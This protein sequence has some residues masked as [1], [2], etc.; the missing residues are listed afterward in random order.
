M[1]LNFTIF[2]L[3]LV[4]GALAGP[5]EKLPAELELPVTVIEGASQGLAAL[6]LSQASKGLLRYRKRL[7]E[8]G[9]HMLV[10]AD[11]VMA[12]AFWH[13]IV[14]RSLFNATALE[15]WFITAGVGWPNDFLNTSPDHYLALNGPGVRQPGKTADIIENWGPG[16][17]THFYGVSEPKPSFI[18]AVDEFPAELQYTVG[19]TLLDGT[20]FAHT[21]TAFRDLP[22]ENGIEVIGD[23]WI[24]S[25]SPDDVIEGLQAHNTVEISNWLKFAWKAA[26][27]AL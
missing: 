8:D 2:L 14:A 1:V 27:A 22:G 15:Q 16:P 19:F 26:M 21:L 10:A 3:A 7:G 6:E 23:F 13:K 5:I 24:P 17:I 4:F 9:T 25:N 11:I 18:P 12:D 20:L